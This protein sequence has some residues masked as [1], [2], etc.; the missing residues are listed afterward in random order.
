MM[1]VACLAP[2]IAQISS[3]SLMRSDVASSVVAVMLSL[4]CQV[5]M[6]YFTSAGRKGLGRRVYFGHN[7]CLIGITFGRLLESL[8]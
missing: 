6:R 5:Q 2:G 7:G 4:S 8:G 1:T 3:A